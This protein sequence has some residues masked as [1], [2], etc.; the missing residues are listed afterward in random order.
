MSEGEGVVQKRIE[1]LEEEARESELLE[2]GSIREIVSI[3]EELALFSDDNLA[4]YYHVIA[5]LYFLHRRKPVHESNL[6][7][8]LEKKQEREDANLLW[9]MNRSRAEYQAYESAIDSLQTLDEKLATGFND[10][11][12]DRFPLLYEGSDFEAY[13]VKHPVSWS[14]GF[15]FKEPDEYGVV[16]VFVDDRSYT[17]FYR[18]NDEFTEKEPLRTVFGTTVTFSDRFEKTDEV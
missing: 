12:L 6:G 1:T 11:M 9:R 10:I 2:L 14:I 15:K 4:S 13:R 5:S 18:S 8:A 3:K 7:Y 16:E 17:S